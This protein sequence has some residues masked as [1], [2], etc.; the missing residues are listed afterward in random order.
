[1]QERK[2]L[3]SFMRTKHNLQGHITMLKD[4]YL[5]ACDGA[6]VYISDHAI[7][8]YLER[9]KELRLHGT[10]DSNKVYTYLRRTGRN[11]KELREEILS[12]KE[13][14]HI[15]SNEVIMYDRQGF[16]YVVKNLALIT[17]YPK[18]K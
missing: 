17:I 4:E 12:E 13:Q 9:V 10:T 1:M 2:K 5:D 15:V 7:V 14:R 16:I 3:L 6:P 18:E 11:P 8:R